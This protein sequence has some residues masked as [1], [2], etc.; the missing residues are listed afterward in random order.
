MNENRE[1]K[2][3]VFSM[4]MEDKAN[5]LEVYNA[6]NGSSYDDPE[7]IELVNLEKGISVSVRNDAAF[8]I[9]A[10][11]SIYEH[12]STYNPNMPLRSL[13]YFVDIIKEHVIKGK[14]VFSSH[15][16]MIPTPHFAV[17]Y[18]GKVNRPS[19]ETLKLSSSFQG[20]TEEPELELFCTVYNINPGKDE[21]L[22][23]KCKA[24]DGYT[25]FVENVR[26]NE[27]E[28]VEN[29]IEK[30]IDYCIANHILEDFFRKRK[31]EVLNAMTID[32]TFEVREGLIREEE[33]ELGR[34]EGHAEGH[35]EEL[36]RQI[37]KK[38]IKGK[39]LDMIID[40]L[41]SS[42]E[43]ITPLYEAV[44]RNPANTNPH[45][46]YESLFKSEE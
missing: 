12:Q 39:D 20:K 17:F 18:N 26:K 28:G 37:Q 34:I 14:D 2:S 31:R 16:V 15:K 44:I 8:I 45:K 46:I 32:M 24:L 23:G 25:T 36:I 35:A 5:A 30:A 9:A 6:L 10:D 27:V 33:H 38:V 21:G 1:F 29:P 19:K 7:Q 3:D 41:E 13:I 11:V 42:E 43:E 22:L 40:E 4:L